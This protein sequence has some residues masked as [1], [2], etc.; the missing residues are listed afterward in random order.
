MLRLTRLTR[1]TRPT[2]ARA[3]AIVAPRL[4][5]ATALVLFAGVT[6][7][8]MGLVAGNARADDGAAARGLVLDLGAD[9]VH[10]ALIAEPLGRAREALE[11]A[12]RLRES[13]DEARAKAADG[14]ALEWAETARD[15]AH[16]AD[17]ERTAADRR[18]EALA[19]L[20]Q[21]ERARALVEA[22]LAHVG[23][24]RKEIEDA[25]GA[26]RTRGAEAD[27]TA[28]EVHDGQEPKPAAKKS[29]KRPVADPTGPGDKP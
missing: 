22:D 18:R 10:A 9:T 23:R 15:L 19:K 26:G 28:V 12:M 16:A 11:R 24:L 25:A 27:R 2:R 13:G 21:V 4:G 8:L 14:L 20:A 1:L 17:A 7:V 3:L 5:S 6:S 29:T